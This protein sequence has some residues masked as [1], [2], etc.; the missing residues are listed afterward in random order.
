LKLLI[1]DLLTFCFPFSAALLSLGGLSLY[2]PLGTVYTIPA[3]L[4]PAA[5]R[6]ASRDTLP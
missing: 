4:H 3:A 5:A 6:T 1:L 2:V